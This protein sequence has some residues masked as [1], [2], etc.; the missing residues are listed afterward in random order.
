MANGSDGFYSRSLPE[1]IILATGSE[2]MVPGIPG[3]QKEKVFSSLDILSGTHELPGDKVLVIGGGTVGLL[4]SV[5]TE[6]E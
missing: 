6:V 1:I 4:S 3:V 2:Q 5:Q